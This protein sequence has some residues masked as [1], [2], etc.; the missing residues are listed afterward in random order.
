M[1]SMIVR[2]VGV[3]SKVTR[4]VLYIP[5]PFCCSKNY[6][7]TMTRHA[8]LSD[9]GK[10]YRAIP[11]IKSAL[12]HPSIVRNQP[13]VH[14]PIIFREEEKYNR[15]NIANGSMRQRITWLRLTKSVTLPP[16]RTLMIRIAGT[17]AS[18]RE[19]ILRSHGRMRQFMKAFHKRPARPMCL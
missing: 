1:C 19:I 2:S 18:V 7:P 12:P 11:V 15:G 6:P 10:L 8:S 5:V 14:A 13:L 4:I 16:P 17:T 3:P 9:S